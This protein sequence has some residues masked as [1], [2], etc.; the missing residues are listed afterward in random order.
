[1]FRSLIEGKTDDLVSVKGKW[2]CLVWVGALGPSER[3][4]EARSFRNQG[5]EAVASLT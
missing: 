5:K 3:R 4:R 1:M 2:R